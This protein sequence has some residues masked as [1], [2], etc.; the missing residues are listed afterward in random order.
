M[1]EH[2]QVLEPIP[3]AWIEKIEKILGVEKVVPEDDMAVVPLPVS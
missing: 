3:V 2:D 1:L